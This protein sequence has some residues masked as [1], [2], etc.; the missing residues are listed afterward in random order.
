[1]RREGTLGKW[2]RARPAL[3]V[4]LLVF[5]SACGEGDADGAAFNNDGW[6]SGGQTGS[7][8]PICGLTPASAERGVPEDAAG[9]VLVPNAC[10][11]ARALDRLSLQDASGQDVAFDVVRLPNGELLVIARGGLTPGQYTLSAG[12]GAADAGITPGDDASI[13]DDAGAEQIEDAG[14]AAPALTQS[15]EITD[16]PMPE[17]FGS[18]ARIYGEC[19]ATL[20][21]TPEASVLPYLALL[22]VELQI[23][24]MRPRPLYTTGTLKLEDGYARVELPEHELDELASG[25]HELRVTVKLAGQSTPLETFLLTLSVPCSEATEEDSSASSG[26][27]CAA[28][29][30]AASA[31][32]AGALAAAMA[33]IAL[34]KRRRRARA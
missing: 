33:L 12:G 11:D 25:S 22:S 14:V 31:R 16:A 34:R 7:L 19:G 4:A 20:E 32:P 18:V 23:D 6:I 10:V 28:A 2:H 30:Y 24:G 8:M 27:A 26:Y 3:L 21:L 5:L 9:L 15:V 13:D 1:M 17:R 29:P